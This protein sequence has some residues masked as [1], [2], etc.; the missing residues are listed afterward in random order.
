MNAAEAAEAEAEAKRL[1]AEQKLQ[2]LEKRDPVCESF[3][4]APVSTHA[5]QRCGITICFANST[6][7]IGMRLLFPINLFQS[8]P[9]A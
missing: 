7:C 1:R 9:T 5:A 2:Q 3:A 8:L 4:T 6:D